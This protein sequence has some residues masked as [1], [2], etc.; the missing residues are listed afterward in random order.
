MKIYL[1]TYKWVLDNVLEVHKVLM[2]IKEKSKETDI[3]LLDYNT[4]TDFRDITKPISHAGLVKAYIEDV[5]P[6]S[7]KEY[8]P[9]TREEL[10]EK[11][12]LLKAQ[13]KEV[14]KKAKLAKESE[15]KGLFD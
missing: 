4:N 10:E 6:D 5:Y 14:K 15:E 11:K 13:K 3:V 1:P 12:A 2:K 8:T 7:S 9:M